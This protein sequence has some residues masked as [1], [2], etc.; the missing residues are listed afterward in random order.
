MEQSES[1]KK[2]LAEASLIV[3]ATSDPAFVEVTERGK[4]PYLVEVKDGKVEV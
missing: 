1:I 4:E 2:L 3:E